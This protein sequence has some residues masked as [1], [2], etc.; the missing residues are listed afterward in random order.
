LKP[1]M[2][3][4]IQKLYGE[5]TK[6]VIVQHDQASSHESRETAAYAEDLK[7]R[8]GIT[9]MKKSEIPVKSPDISPIDFFGFGYLKQRLFSKK[10]RT[11]EGLWKVAIEDW[12]SKTQFMVQRVMKSWKRRCRLVKLTKGRHIEPITKIQSRKVKC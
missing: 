11:L 3:G 9:I 6:N 1:W 2:E 12:F 10:P 7:S 5:E 4:E 8:L